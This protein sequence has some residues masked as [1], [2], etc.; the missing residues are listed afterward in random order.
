MADLEDR[1]SQWGD[2]QHAAKSPSDTRMFAVALAVFVVAALTIGCKTTTDRAHDALDARIDCV[3]PDASAVEVESRSSEPG[4]FFVF[5]L[6]ADG[7]PLLV[8]I[9][10]RANV[11]WVKVVWEGDESSERDCAPWSPT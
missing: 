4:D 6:T 7:K 8:E 10:K 9:R 11:Y 1:V 3:A 5:E 2:A